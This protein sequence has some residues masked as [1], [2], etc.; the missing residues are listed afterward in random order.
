M[1]GAY[2]VAAGLWHDRADLN[3]LIILSHMQLKT[4]DSHLHG[5]YL[6]T[7]AIKVTLFL[8]LLAFR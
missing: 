4:R 8:S 3:K 5:S 7:L 2:Q 6:P 1:R